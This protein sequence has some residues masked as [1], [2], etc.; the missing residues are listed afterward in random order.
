MQSSKLHFSSALTAQ[1]WQDDVSIAVGA[2]GVIEGVVANSKDGNHI[3]GVAVPAVANVHSHAHQ[4]LMLGL[5]ERA[6]KISQAYRAGGTS[7]RNRASS[8]TST[9][10]SPSA[11]CRA[12]QS[13]P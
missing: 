7:A 3:K 6:G 8:S 12:L 11:R 4:R 1:G 2:N 13:M 10:A 9:R 5:A